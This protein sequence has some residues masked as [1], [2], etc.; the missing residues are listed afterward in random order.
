MLCRV[1]A[2]AAEGFRVGV[3]MVEGV[4]EAV[5]RANVQEPVSAVEVD[6]APDRDEE[7]DE[8]VEGQ[9]LRGSLDF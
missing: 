5:E 6:V 3:S 8:G 7:Q 2:Q 1:H 9:Q 4:D